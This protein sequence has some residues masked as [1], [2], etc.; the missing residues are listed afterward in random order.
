MI[1][2]PPGIPEPLTTAPTSSWEVSST[3]MTGLFAVVPDG[4]TILPL[5]MIETA[6]AFEEVALIFP[7]N[8]IL[9]APNSK[10]G[11]LPPVLLMLILAS[12]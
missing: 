3:L 1:V 12:V 5:R 2:A 4:L 10:I 7:F 6:E 11:A 8:V 9:P